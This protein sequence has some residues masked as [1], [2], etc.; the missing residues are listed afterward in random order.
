M[1]VETTGGRPMLLDPLV[2]PPPST[3]SWLLPPL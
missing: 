1:G 3:L 2:S